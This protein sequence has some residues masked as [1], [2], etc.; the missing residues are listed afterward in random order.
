MCQRAAA[1]KISNP[2]NTA[3]QSGPVRPPRP[4]PPRTRAWSTKSGS[5]WRRPC[6][7]ARADDLRPNSIRNLSL[8]RTKICGP[9]C[10]SFFLT[11]RRYRQ[12]HAVRP[13][14]RISPRPSPWHGQPQ[15]GVDQHVSR[16][17]LVGQLQAEPRGRRSTSRRSTVPADQPS[18]ASSTSPSR[19]RSYNPDP[20]FQQRPVRNQAQASYPTR[21]L[22]PPRYRYVGGFLADFV[23]STAVLPDDY[24]KIVSG[25]GTYVFDEDGHRLLDAGGHSGA[26][27]I[28]HRGTIAVAKSPSWIHRA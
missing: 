20:P 2:L 1:I 25:E 14:P 26:C 12:R 3:T 17:N 22:P 10:R 13:P 15:N 16:D 5:L 19:T 23:S 11:T 6:Q 9:C 18:G 21:P 7:P 8:P 4:L 24:P 27:Q 28:G